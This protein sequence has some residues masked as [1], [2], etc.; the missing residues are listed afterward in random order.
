MERRSLSRIVRN[1]E[2]RIQLNGASGR[3]GALAVLTVALTPLVDVR[4]L[5]T[6]AF[7]RG[8]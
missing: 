6:G 8:V 1:G 7:A 4:P 2:S 5:R 3:S